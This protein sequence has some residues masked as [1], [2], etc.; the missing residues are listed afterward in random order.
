MFQ[1]LEKSQFLKKEE[2]LQDKEIKELLKEKRVVF[3]MD[4][5]LEI[6]LRN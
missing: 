3:V 6:L 5:D 1:V 4:Q 2:E